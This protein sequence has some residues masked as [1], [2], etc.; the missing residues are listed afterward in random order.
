MSLKSSLYELISHSEDNLTVS[1]TVL[2]MCLILFSTDNYKKLCFIM[3]N[4]Y[5]Q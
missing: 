2:Y 3:T 5:V 1:L 4:P